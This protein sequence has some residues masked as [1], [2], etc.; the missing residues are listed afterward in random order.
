MPASVETTVFRRLAEEG[1]IIEDF[2]DPRVFPEDRRRPRPMAAERR[3]D[4][5][6]IQG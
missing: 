5:R 6:K 3:L 1:L 2:L 4:R